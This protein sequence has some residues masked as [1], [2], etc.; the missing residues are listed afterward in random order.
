MI[1]CLRRTRG[2][3]HDIR[4]RGLK[5]ATLARFPDR[6]EATRRL[7]NM[8]IAVLR[9]LRHI[10]TLAGPIPETWDE[11]LVSSLHESGRLKPKLRH[12]HKRR[13]KRMHKL[14][15]KLR[16]KLKR[17]HKL[18]P[19]IKICCSD[20]SGHTMATIASRTGDTR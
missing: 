4:R 13:H 11:T 18:K 16:R 2:C 20:S 8:T 19:S 6:G 15:H 10:R 7:R 12:K 17:K 3:T 14:R 1:L 5:A 9:R